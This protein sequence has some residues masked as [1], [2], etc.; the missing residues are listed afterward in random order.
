MIYIIYQTETDG[1]LAVRPLKPEETI[2]EV[3]KE[4]K[5]LYEEIAIFDGYLV[6]D[7][8]NKSFTS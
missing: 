2:K 4:L 7:F 3:A 8:G 1:E 5:L 6:K